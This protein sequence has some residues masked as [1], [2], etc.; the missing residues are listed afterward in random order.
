[1]YHIKFSFINLLNP[2]TFDL[3]MHVYTKKICFYI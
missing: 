2:F 1:M 3:C